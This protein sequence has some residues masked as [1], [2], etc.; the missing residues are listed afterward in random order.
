MKKLN[1]KQK[2]KIVYVVTAV[3]IVSI[4]IAVV[5]NLAAVKASAD[6]SYVTLVANSAEELEW[7]PTDDIIVVENARNVGLIGPDPV[8]VEYQNP[9]NTPGSISGTL[10][11]MRSVS[12]DQSFWG[13]IYFSIILRSTTGQTEK[14]NCQLHYYDW[15]N[16]GFYESYWSEYYI[17][18][19]FTIVTFCFN[20]ASAIFT[21]GDFI[22][23]SEIG[24][25]RT[26][27]LGCFIGTDALSIARNSVALCDYHNNTIN[28]PAN[29]VYGTDNI[30][31]TIL[32]THTN[33]QPQDLTIPWTNFYLGFICSTVIDGT[34]VDLIW[35]VAYE[36][37]QYGH[38]TFVILDDQYHDYIID[39]DLDGAVTYGQIELDIENTNEFDVKYIAVSDNH[40]LLSEDLVAKVNEYNQLGDSESY[41]AGY[42]DGY[43][44]GIKQGSIGPFANAKMIVEFSIKELATNIVTEGLME[45]PFDVNAGGI[46]FE[47]VWYWYNNSEFNDPAYAVQAV[48]ISIY[49]TKPLLWKNTLFYFGNE[50]NSSTFLPLS[51]SVRNAGTSGNTL[52]S[53]ALD[54]IGDYFYVTL[55][56]VEYLSIEAIEFTITNSDA[57]YAD[58]FVTNKLTL[59]SDINQ[60]IV[61]EMSYN[62]GEEAGYMNGYDYGFSQGE[63]QAQT[64]AFSE[65]RE[66]GFADGRQVGYNEGYEQGLQDDFRFYDLF[67]SLFDAQL[68]TFKSVVSFEI[69]GINVA[70]FVLGLV[71]IGIVAF[72]IRKVW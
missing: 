56:S 63:L 46:S 3:I 57:S 50:S 12:V 26:E 28:P 43:A 5:C 15:D 13:N 67:F 34:T 7:T 17:T 55:D 35:S 8:F 45:F 23:S 58:I 31:K 47:N 70:G 53:A 54:Q 59:Y 51:V 18:D 27:I 72:V 61:D 6:N 44:A 16:S 14:W 42:A 4:I 33:Y 52:Y 49:L 25:G 66:A 20:N 30:V 36:D 64:V 68:N 11:Y 32:S 2:E 65:G 9:V 41:N 40:T 37:N 69:F 29:V 21:S 24:Y 62:L 1:N 48:N 60:V 22:I 39:V 10:M 71:T 38:G 19:T